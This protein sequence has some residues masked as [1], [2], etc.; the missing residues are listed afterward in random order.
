[1]YE[2][3]IKRAKN[4]QTIAWCQVKTPKEFKKMLMAMIKKYDLCLARYARP[5]ADTKIYTTG[6]WQRPFLLIVRR[7]TP[8]QLGAFLDIAEKTIGYNGYE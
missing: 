5:S 8:E 2:F 6:D 4:R 7:N 3:I 1:M